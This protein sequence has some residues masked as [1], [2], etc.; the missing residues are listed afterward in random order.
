M[1]K[2]PFLKLNGQLRVSCWLG[3]KLRKYDCNGEMQLK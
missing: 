3:K 1:K 2:T